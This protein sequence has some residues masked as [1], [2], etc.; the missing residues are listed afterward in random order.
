MKF[1]R[2]QVSVYLALVLL[3]IIMLVMMNVGV[4]LA[5]SA[6]NKT[7]NAGDAAA[8]SVAKM[9]GEILNRIGVDNVLH[10]KAALAGDVEKCAEIET[11]QLRS[12]FLDPLEGIR[13]G[14][15]AAEANGIEIDDGMAEILSR[16]VRD[17]RLYYLTNPRLYPEPWEGAWE[18]YA[19]RLE[20]AIAGGVRAGPDN[21]NFMNGARDHHLID[22][23]FYEA[24]LGRNWCWFKFNAP[25]LISSYSSF[26]NSISSTCF[27]SGISAVLA[28]IGVCNGYISTR[29][30]VIWN[31]LSNGINKESL[32]TFETRCKVSAVGRSRRGS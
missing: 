9:Q 22:K 11:R 2:G 12:C 14:S 20:L 29:L 26:D 1:H 3:A 4:F 13:I 21:A 32:T 28:S 5:V 7:M 18:E 30:P 24:V 17:I 23:G 31:V 6:K 27:N 19:Q 15:E 8:I 16:H 25:G 10:L